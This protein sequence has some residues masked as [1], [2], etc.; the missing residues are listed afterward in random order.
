MQKITRL[1][2]RTRRTHAGKQAGFT[3][4]E[5]LIATLVFSMVLLLIAV[6]VLQFNH[7]YYSGITQ[8][9]T[10]NTARNILEQISQDI[11]FSG[12]Q[13]VSPIRDSGLGTDPELGFC[14]GSDRYSYRPGWE[15]VNSGPV[16]ANHQTL[17]ALVKDS[18]GICS[19]MKAQ[20]FRTLSNPLPSGDTELLTQYMRISKISVTAVSGTTGLYNVDVRVV[21]GDD[22]LL[23]NPTTS[24]A[25]C[26]S[27]SGSQFCA[28][29]ELST[30][31]QQRIQ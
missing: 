22:D 29:S 16:V 4:I 6:G 14:I 17:H 19:G 9:E 20:N 1:L 11:Q 23:S 18:P 24:T 21:Y 26:K 8:T 2:V 7:A 13:V 12:S 5:L 28:V 25:T 30:V 31:V 15:L 27:G 3:I 10:Q